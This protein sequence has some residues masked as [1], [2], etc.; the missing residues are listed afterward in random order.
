MWLLQDLSHFDCRVVRSAHID[1]QPGA[2][3][4]N[5]TRP[6]LL[7]MRDSSRDMTWDLNASHIL[8]TWP[9][10]DFSTD[11]YAALMVASRLVWWATGHCIYDGKAPF[12]STQ[13]DYRPCDGQ[14]A[15][16]AGHE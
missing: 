13:S 9:I 1:L 10:P 8:L 4:S 3:R 15:G 16:T 5:A 11:D 6:A 2:I 7:Q 14:G 12:L